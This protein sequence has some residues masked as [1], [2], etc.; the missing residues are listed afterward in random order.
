[1]TGSDLRFDLVVATLDRTSPLERLLETLE[2]QTYRRFRVLIVD[3]NTDG[4]VKAILAAHPSL[5]IVHLTSAVGLSRA[6]NVALDALDADVVAFPD[7]DCGY[8]PDLLERVANVLTERLDLDGVSGIL[9]EASGARSD[10]WPSETRRV[11]ID[12]VWH[13]GCSGSIFLRRSLFDQIG[14]FD[15]RMGFGSGNPWELAE[16]IDVLA[17]SILAGATIEQD[18]TLVVEHVHRT[19]EGPAL[20]I[21]ARQSGSGAGYVLGKNRFP[22]RVIARMMLRP[23]GGVLKSLLRADLPGVR[24]QLAILRWRALGYRA[25]RRARI[26]PNKVA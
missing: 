14:Y 17:R 7:D 3:Q 11:T 10:R 6:R 9:S 2:H 24:F 1:M 18:P 25:G 23:V 16:E 19:F 4:R 5:E 22:G 26:S 12:N 8:P 13:G 15:E 20:A 21:Y